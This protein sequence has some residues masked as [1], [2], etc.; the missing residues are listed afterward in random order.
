MEI[1]AAF[2]EHIGRE[3]RLSDNTVEA[4]GHDLRGFFTFL[5]GHLDQAVGIKMFRHLH[6][7]DIRAFLASR[8]RDGLSDA[9]IARVLSAIKAFY[10]WLDHHHGIDNPEIAFLQG[11]KRSARL[12]RPVSVAVARDMIGT[13]EAFAEEPWVAARDVAVLTLLYG[14]GLRISEALDLNGDALPLPERLRV[15]GK[16]GK[17]RIVPM[18]PAVREAVHAYA[19]LC[20]YPLTAQAPLFYG[21]RGKRLQPAIVQKGVQIL[22]GA[23]GLPDTATPH[24][25]RHAFATHLLAEGADLRAIQTLLGHASLST[26]Q[27]YTGVDSERLR[28]VHASAHPRG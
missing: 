11:P 25:L 12:P 26:T 13:A 3:R 9:S 23:L 28:A 14:G 27:V 1:L 2:L 21:V 7:S 6:A 24:A 8:R 19:R 18:I 10:H 20:P 5:E 15:K 4:Y 17:V 22:R 16:G